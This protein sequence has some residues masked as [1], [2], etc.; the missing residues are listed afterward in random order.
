MA[1][2]A[3][4][5]IAELSTSIDPAFARGIVESYGEMQQ[6][7]LAG[8]W[9]P[10]ELDGGRLC[11]AVARGLYQLDTG[12]STQTELPGTLSDLMEDF[13][14]KRAHN[15]A[16]G[17]RHHFCKAIRLVY[18]LRSDRGPVHISPIYTANYM[19]SMMIVHVCKWMFGEFLRLAWNADKDVV[20]A[21]I[22]QIVQLEHALIHE[23]DGKPLVLTRG[24]GAAEEVLLLLNHAVGN[25][26]SRA[27]I[28]DYA[29]RQK[30]PTLNA[31]I[32]KLIE[33]ATRER[34]TTG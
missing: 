7:F 22:E 17:D 19:D 9:Q 13:H 24:I 14:K 2:S 32:T 29:K 27:Q 6:R 8:D 20:A 15:L 23:L 31:A 11:E 25:R 4:Q 3:S 5:L 33:I 28:R 12:M 30:P 21:T 10:A 16:A 26:L 34:K 18:K 1:L